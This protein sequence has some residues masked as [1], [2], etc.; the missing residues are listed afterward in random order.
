[1]PTR[2]PAMLTR[3]APFAPLFSR[4]V[5]CHALVLVAGTLLAPGKRTV[6]AA[7]R[8]MGL[9]Q[10]PHWTR[11]QRVRNRAKW[12]RLAVSRVLLGLLVATF[13]PTGP[14]I[15]GLD[16]TLARR[17]PQAGTRPADRRAGA[18]PRRGAVQSGALRQSERAALA[19]RDAPGAAPLGRASVG[20]ALPHHP[21]PLRAA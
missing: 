2:P 12:S 1:M 13:A 6:C 16:E 5:W 18:R 7:L 3:L 20:L 17:H 10:T 9:H 15:V 4:R 19:V 11:D 21:G 8:A 14:L